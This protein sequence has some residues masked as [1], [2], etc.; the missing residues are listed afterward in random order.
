MFRQLFQRAFFFLLI[1]HLRVS[2]LQ[3]RLFADEV[4][5][6]RRQLVQ[7]FNPTVAVNDPMPQRVQVTLALLHG[8]CHLT[9]TEKQDFKAARQRKKK[10]KTN[11]KRTAR[12]TCPCLPLVFSD[13]LWLKMHAKPFRSRRLLNSPVPRLPQHSHCN[14]PACKFLAAPLRGD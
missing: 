2:K 7:K 14:R 11:Q 13:L 8:C 12:I 9:P 5:Q 4:A 1:S 10:K 3:Y 6:E